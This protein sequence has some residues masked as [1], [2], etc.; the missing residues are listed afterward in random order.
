MPQLSVDEL[1]KLQAQ[2]NLLATLEPVSDE[3]EQVKVTPWSEFGGCQCT[4][5]R[6]VAKSAIKHVDPTGKIHECCG[7]L[8]QVVSVTFAEDAVIPLSSVF[9]TG[10]PQTP[11]AANIG[12]AAQPLAGASP[13]D[14]PLSTGHSPEGMAFAGGGPGHPVSGYCSQGQYFILCGNHSGCVPWGT[15]CCWNAY[16]CPPGARCCYYLGRYTCC[17]ESTGLPIY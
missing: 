10:A 9:T 16:T 1:F 2:P 5:A 17:N 14:T 15:K 6:I 3:S 4:H 7:K 12:F 13:F 8:L 11:P